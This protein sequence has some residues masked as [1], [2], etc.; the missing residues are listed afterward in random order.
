MGVGWH[1]PESSALFQRVAE[2]CRVD[3]DSAGCFELSAERRIF[4]HIN[5]TVVHE[6]CGGRGE[7]VV[8]GVDE[9]AQGVCCWT[10]KYS[11]AMQQ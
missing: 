5:S 8:V 4:P 9:T 3:Y 2:T 1:G 11:R 10:A 6:S 7:S